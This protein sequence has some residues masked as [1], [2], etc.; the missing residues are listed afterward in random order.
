MP[1]RGPIHKLSNSKCW[2]HDRLQATKLCIPVTRATRQLHKPR[3]CWCSCYHML[4]YSRDSQRASRRPHVRRAAPAANRSVS[5]V[6]NLPVCQV[7]V[8]RG[9]GWHMNR[10]PTLSKNPGRQS[11]VIRLQYVSSI[12][13]AMTACADVLTPPCCLQFLTGRWCWLLDVGLTRAYL[14]SQ[15]ESATHGCAVCRVVK[16]DTPETLLCSDPLDH[17]GTATT[18]TSA[19]YAIMWAAKATTLLPHSGKWGPRPEGVSQGSEKQS[20]HRMSPGKAPK[21]PA[22]ARS[23]SRAPQKQRAQVRLSVT[24]YTRHSWRCRLEDAQLFGPEE[25]AL[26]RLLGRVVT[27]PVFEARWLLSAHLHSAAMHP[28]CE[29]HMRQSLR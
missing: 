23:S 10:S 7:L 19:I 20:P 13:A 6:Q 26:G 29:F 3:T 8:E 12:T 2:R 15:S 14:E 24:P 16:R 17:M 27:G 22:A 21:A 18:V 28:Q 11:A 5:W 25:L 1:L 9:A 4:M